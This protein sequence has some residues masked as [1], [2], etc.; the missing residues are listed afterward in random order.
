MW[1]A[2]RGSVLP[3][4]DSSSV[5]VGPNQ[6]VKEPLKNCTSEMSAKPGFQVLGS[7]V[8]EYRNSANHEMF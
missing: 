4:G 7:R 8:Y 2:E 3:N 1:S 5:V 6:L